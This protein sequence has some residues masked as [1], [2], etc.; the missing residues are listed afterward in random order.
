MEEPLP[1]RGLI[2][3]AAIGIG[4]YAM[5]FGA[6]AARIRSVTAAS[7]K[8]CD[9]RSCAHDSNHVKHVFLREA[10]D[11]ERGPPKHAARLQSLRAFPLARPASQREQ[12]RGGN[13]LGKFAQGD[14]KL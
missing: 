6:S 14:Y 1:E 8:H 13:R 9:G 4:L 2:F 7:S 10:S 5:A 12:P 3:R 11:V